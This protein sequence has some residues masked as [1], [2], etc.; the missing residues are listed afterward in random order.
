MV[1]VRKVR[2]KSEGISNEATATVHA[3]RKKDWQIERS[4]TSIQ[5]LS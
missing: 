5:M 1:T 3:K 2:G 4:E